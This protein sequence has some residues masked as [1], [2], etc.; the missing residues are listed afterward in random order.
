MDYEPLIE[1]C[2]NA[3]GDRHVL[4]CAI[5]AGGR[6]IITANLDDFKPE[7]LAPWGIKA[8]HPQDFLLELYKKDRET[9]RAAIDEQ[10]NQQDATVEARSA[11]MQRHV[12]KFVAELFAEMQAR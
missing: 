11:L 5:K 10:A 7:A 12:P 1:Q 8:V 6:R 2:T 9:V 4:A 3:V